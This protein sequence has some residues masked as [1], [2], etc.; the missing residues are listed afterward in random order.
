M[1]LRITA[2]AAR[3]IVDFTRDRISEL[4]NEF[5]PAVGWIVGDTDLKR[6]TPRLAVG[7]AD[8]NV[9]QGRFLECD[10]IDCG[11]AQILPE[12]VIQRLHH[13]DI[14]LKDGELAFVENQSS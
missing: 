13:H 7:I 9:V 2:E 10:G 12:K 4:G 3:A 8:K 11:I 5:V 6:P 1:T 14:G